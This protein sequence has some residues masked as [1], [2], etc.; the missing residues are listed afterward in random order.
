[1]ADDLPVPAPSSSPPL[2]REA[3]ER[4]LARA[5]ELQATE[6][7]PSEPALSEQQLIDVGKEVGLS[8]QHLRQAMAEERS[9]VVAP[10]EGG[11]M[12]R[13][14]GPSRVHASR[15]V[16]GTPTQAL[17]SLDGWMQ[18]EESLQV[19]RRFPDRILWDP[20]PGALSWMRR[21]LNLGGRSYHLLRVEE[22]GATAIP[23]DG[24][25][26]LVRLDADVSNL[27]AERLAG[28]GA[29]A[30]S[31]LATTG[32]AIALGFFAPIAVVPTLIGLVGGYAVSRTHTP[33]IARAQLALEQVLDRLERG[34]L[35]RASV[36]GMLGV[37]GMR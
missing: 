22:V 19:K 29:F 12:A 31:G 4:V 10:V 11:V 34:E 9:R 32:V 5:A 21:A 2:D 18:R 6:A 17:A 14:F 7:D 30:A 27:R 37:A 1:M 36:V 33:Q 26:T 25:R 15:T 13:L 28:G 20:R 23:V 24:E 8:P 3:L 35:G 16:R